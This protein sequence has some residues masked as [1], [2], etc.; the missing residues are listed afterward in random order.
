[1]TWHLDPPIRVGRR[2]F[3]AV[4]EIDISAHS[5]GPMVMA[6]AG[7]WPCTILMLDEGRITALDLDGRVHSPDDTV[8]TY[9]DAVAQFRAIQADIPNSG[10]P[11]Q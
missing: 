11:N 8:R 9:H 6:S 5:A 4:T 10:D 7:K 3:A 2:L 1:M